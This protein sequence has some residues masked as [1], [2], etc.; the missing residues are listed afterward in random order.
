MHDMPR[1]RYKFSFPLS[2]I[3]IFYYLQL[4]CKINHKLAN[5]KQLLISL[6]LK[7]IN[8]AKML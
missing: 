2:F 6:D 3:S 8:K 5:K 4:A 1:H 7:V